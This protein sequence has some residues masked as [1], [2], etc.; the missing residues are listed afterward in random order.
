MSKFVNAFAATR[1]IGM[2]CL[3]AS[4]AGAGVMFGY[5]CANKGEVGPCACYGMS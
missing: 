5:V 4:V 1:T 3:S 2:P